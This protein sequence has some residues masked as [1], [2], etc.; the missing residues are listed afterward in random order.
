MVKLPNWLYEPLPFLYV[1]A[2][3]FALWRLDDVVGE[4]S[5]LLLIS[6]GL[7]IANMRHEYRKQARAQAAARHHHR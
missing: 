1:A 4:L 2:G 5:G 3:A 6:A 7:V